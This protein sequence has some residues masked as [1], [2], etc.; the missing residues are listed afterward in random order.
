MPP[1]LLKRKIPVL[2]GISNFLAAFCNYSIMYFFPMWFQ[3]VMASSASIAGECDSMARFHKF[4]NIT[5]RL[6]PPAEQHLYDNR[7]HV[8][9]VRTVF[10]G[11]YLLLTLSS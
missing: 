8:R 6:A 10:Y 7:I 11:I 5:F 4:M 3:T 2:V 1:F 9:R